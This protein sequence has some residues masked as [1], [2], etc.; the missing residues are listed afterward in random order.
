METL[1]LKLLSASGV[2]FPTEAPAA[3]GWGSGRH[4]AAFLCPT[5]GFWCPALHSF[6]TTCLMHSP[7]GK[8]HG[9]QAKWELHLPSW[10]SPTA[11]P[12]VL[13]TSTL[14]IQPYRSA[15]PFL[16]K[17]FSPVLDLQCHNLSPLPCVELSGMSRTRLWHL[18]HLCP[19]THSYGSSFAGRFCLEQLRGPST[20]LGCVLNSNFATI[21]AL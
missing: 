16:G 11:Q 1:A 8:K 10:S 14:M 12:Q 13:S 18:L 15:P 2:M 20:G 17:P 5:P 9:C 3:M 19:P 7:P 6:A 4:C 21:S